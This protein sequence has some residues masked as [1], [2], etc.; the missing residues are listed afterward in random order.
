[1][2]SSSLKSK[3]LTSLQSGGQV[4][5]KQFAAWFGTTVSTISARVSE[6]RSEGYSIY[7]N[8]HKDTKG[9]MT[10]MYRIGKPTR[11]VVAAGY[12]ALGAS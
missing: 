6:L 9:R 4:S 3:I 5:A 12:A 11:A 7:N 2:A 10:K 1:M 8:T